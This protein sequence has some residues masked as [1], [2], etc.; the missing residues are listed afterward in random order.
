MEIALIIGGLATA[1]L[2]IREILI[3]TN[4]NNNK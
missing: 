4:N 2:I 1:L 3:R